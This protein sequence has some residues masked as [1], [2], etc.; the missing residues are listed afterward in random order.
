MSS[1]IF[2]IL[3]AIIIHARVHT[4]LRVVGGLQL[5]SRGRGVEL[6]SFEKIARAYF[7][8]VCVRV[9]RNSEERVQQQREEPN[10]ALCLSHCLAFRV[11]Y[12]G[13]LAAR[14]DARVCATTER[15]LLPAESDG[16]QTR[17]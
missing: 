10:V 3:N 6:L 15:F 8:C 2:D 11:F 9:C 4:A 14:R 17:E 16:A 1:V 5:A 13:N 12:Y 7:H